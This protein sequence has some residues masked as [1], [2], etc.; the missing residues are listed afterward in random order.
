MFTL[1]VGVGD[2]AEAFLASCVPDLQF[3]VFALGVDRLEPEIHS[4]G[5]HIVFVELVVGKS[6]QQAALA[7]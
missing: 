4:D 2:S 7:H 6:Q 5:G 3:D 1:V